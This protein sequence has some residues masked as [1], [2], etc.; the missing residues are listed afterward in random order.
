[1][2]HFKNLAAAGLCLLIAVSNVQAGTTYKFTVSFERGTYVESWQAGDID[3][4]EEYL[5][6]FTGTKHLG[7]S[8]GD[9]KPVYDCRSP[10]TRHSDADGA[11]DGLPPVAIIKKIFGL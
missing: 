9:F 2:K 11:I 10:E 3:P 6:V 4:E 8:V 1:M 5:R 7:C